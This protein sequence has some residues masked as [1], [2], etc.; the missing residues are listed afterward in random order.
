MTTPIASELRRDDALGRY[1][2]EEFLIGLPR[3]TAVDA[4]VQDA[5]NLIECTD[6]ALYRSTSNGRNLVSTHP[7][8]AAATPPKTP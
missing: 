3:T 2:G 1:G 6:A 7:G 5:E 8:H 4:G